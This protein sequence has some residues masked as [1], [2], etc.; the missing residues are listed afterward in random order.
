MTKTNCKYVLKWVGGSQRSHVQFCQ[1]SCCS[2]AIGNRKHGWSGWKQSDC[3]LSEESSPDEISCL[4]GK[5][6]CSWESDCIDHWIACSSEVQY[7]PYSCFDSTQLQPTLLKIWLNLA[8][9]FQLMPPEF[10]SPIW[11]RDIGQN[12]KNEKGHQAYS[13]T[14][15]PVFKSN[16]YNT[17]RQPKTSKSE[18]SVIT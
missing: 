14:Q 12:R 9:L 1:S 2:I 5:I 6:P 3:T 13:K 11:M 10:R 8:R 4:E 7:Y 16:L 15:F 17:I 18:S